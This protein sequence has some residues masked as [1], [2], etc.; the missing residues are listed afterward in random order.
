MNLNATSVA[1]YL[2]KVPEERKPAF[3]KLRTTILENIPKGFEEILNY[4]MVAYVVSHT[5]YPAGYHCDPQ[6][7]LP[8]AGIASQKNI[9]ALYHSGLYVNDNLMDWFVGEFPRHSSQKLDMGKSC[10]RFKN[11]DKIPFELVGALFQKI[12]VDDWIQLYEDN[13]IKKSVRAKRT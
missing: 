3:N 13:Y 2:Q 5:I 10:I 9:I 4:G 8:F 12:S 6:L 7:P 1:E 11:P